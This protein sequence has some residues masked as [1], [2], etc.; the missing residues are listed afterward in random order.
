MVTEPR[1]GLDDELLLA[2]A[3]SGD[4][5]AFAEIYRRH[6]PLV[7]SY[8][9]RQT[10][11][12]DLAADLAAETF[13]AALSSLRRGCSKPPNAVAWLLRIAHNK[14][15]DSLRRGRVEEA[16]R[17]R[18]KLE[19]IEMH[20]EDIEQVERIAS[21]TDLEAALEE[22]LTLDELV[23]VRARVLDERDYEEISRELKIS[24]AVVRKRV[25]RGLGALREH[26][27]V[28]RQGG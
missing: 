16:A 23:A 4:G 1:G 15:V 27:G 20:D 19:R 18:L 12:P 17:Q 9:C 28:R 8:L 7:L 3:A 11:R 13:V 21:E 2:L 6:L 24:N 22:A 10:R 5:E 14:L 26:L 25:S